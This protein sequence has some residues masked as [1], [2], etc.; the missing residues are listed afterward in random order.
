MSAAAAYGFRL[1]SRETTTSGSFL[2]LEEGPRKAPHRYQLLNVLDFTS[3]RKRMSVVVRD[4]DGGRLFL[5][6]KGADNIIKSL[7]HG[8]QEQLATVTDG[9]LDEYAGTGLRTLMLGMR[10]LE[11]A[12]Y[13][14]WNRKYVE[15][16]TS[17]EDRAAKIAA[18]SLEMERDLQLLGASAI[19]DKL[20]EGVPEAIARLT[21][22]GI[23]VWVLTGDRKD[24]AINVGFAS[25]LLLPHYKLIVVDAD[26]W[27]QTQLQLKDALETYIKPRPMDNSAPEYALIIEGKTLRHALEP[28]NRLHLLAVATQCKAVICCRVGPKQKSEVVALVKNTL[29]Q[30]VLSIGDGANDVPMIKEAHVGVGISGKEGRQAVMSADYAIG[31]FG[32]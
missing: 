29:S 2:T 31:Q 20:Q 23:K 11:A 24:T 1:V 8:G 16:S 10:E 7:L 14:E 15:A 25:R 4:C 17:M 6:C 32:E 28:E 12:E 19:E 9:H 18:V 5:L 13:V 3:D 22:A 21:A 30:V 26:E 27:H